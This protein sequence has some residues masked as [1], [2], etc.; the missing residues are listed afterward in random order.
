M[1]NIV[2]LFGII[3]LVVVIGFS[4]AACGGDDNGGGGIEMSFAYSSMRGEGSVW[5]SFDGAVSSDVRPL[6]DLTEDFKL[7]ID[8]ADVNITG[9][10]FI[11]GDISLALNTNSYTD[12]TAYNI[13][14]TYT[15]NDTRPIVYMESKK[16]LGAFTKTQKVKFEKN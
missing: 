5:V 2:K 7:T 15:P 3:A 11:G 8:G 10:G 9:V 4:M 1:K 6:K 12:G 14:V 16:P 13:S